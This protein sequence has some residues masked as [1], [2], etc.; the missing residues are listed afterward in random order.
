MP[1]R[2]RA[3]PAPPVQDEYEH[4][5]VLSKEDFAIFDFKDP[6]DP[7]YTELEYFKNP[8]DAIKR[9]INALDM[10]E[11]EQA[12]TI[13]LL[14]NYEVSD[15]VDM[16]IEDVSLE[17]L[18]TGDY[19]T[20]RSH[21]DKQV[22]D[23]IKALSNML[24]SFA[25]YKDR[26]D[27]SW[28]IRK[29][30]LLFLEL[31]ENVL[32]NNQSKSKIEAYLY[33]IMR[34]MKHALG[35]E[36]HVLYA[37]YDVIYIM[38]RDDIRQDEGNNRLNKAEL[39]KGGLIDWN[40][41]LKKQ[42]EFENGFNNTANK[43]TRTA[44]VLNQDL[45]LLSFYTLIP[46]LRAEVRTLTFSEEGNLLTIE[47]KGN[48]ILFENNDI[49]LELHEIK[50]R[51]GFIK[52]SLPSNLKKIIRESY[53]LY[54]RKS[55]FTNLNKYP[56]FDEAAKPPAVGLR[57]KNM[58]DGFKVGSSM[59]RSSYVTYMYAKRPRINFNKKKWMAQ[60]MRTS[61]TMLE[62]AYHKILDDDIVQP[63]QQPVA[64]KHKATKAV[65]NRDDM[66]DDGEEEDDE[67][68]GGCVVL[69]NRR[70]NQNKNDKSYQSHLD[71][72]KKYY[73]DHKATILN[74]QKRYRDANPYKENRRKII[75]KLNKYDGYKDAIQQLTIDKYD[76]K[77]LDNGR[78]V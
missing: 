78:F 26:D 30:R 55:V 38:V 1:R 51:H 23:R 2:R 20:G 29:H 36:R 11:F 63:A 56:N 33:A 31:L 60:Q 4:L 32:G 17:E 41:V 45:L 69:I 58:F 48:L 47:R 3:A 50:K 35:S 54:P 10:S 59:L 66:E 34:V 43:N 68:E 28:I 75:A 44:Y 25:Q 73:N 13:K 9:R 72:Q 39:A 15:I 40:V 19:Q 57:L 14:A 62:S 27:I 24:P 8:N 21:S 71:Q 46:P 77:K 37:K 42:Q 22:S 5:N 64:V 61:V 70:T 52:L 6:L 16:D 12:V 65:G 74:K 67:Q 18:K 53:Q 7:V 49:F 76:I